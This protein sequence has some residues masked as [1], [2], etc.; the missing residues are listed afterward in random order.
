MGVCWEVA[1]QGT[2]GTRGRVMDLGFPNLFG[3]LLSHPLG[4]TFGLASVDYTGLLWRTG[5][6]LSQLE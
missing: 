6:G 4:P 3:P 1:A 2:E 5:G